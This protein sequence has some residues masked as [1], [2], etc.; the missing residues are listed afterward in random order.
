MSGAPIPAN[1]QARLAELLRY[2]ILD[3]AREAEFDGLTRLAAELC[4]SPIALISLVDAERQWFKSQV[5][6]DVQETPRKLA[7][8]AHSILGEGI[9]EV[10]DASKD[11]RFADNALVTGEPDIRFYAGAPLRSSEGF[12]LGTV[13]V[14]DRV[15]RRLSAAQRDGLAAIGRQVMSLLSFRRAMKEARASDSHG[16]VGASDLSVGVM[17]MATLPGPRGAPAR[18]E[19]GSEASMKVGR[20]TTLYMLGKGAMATVYAAHDRELQRKVA[21][22]FIHG[23]GGADEQQRFRHEAQALARISHPNVVQ[24][25]DSWAV[26]ARTFIAM[27]FVHGVTLAVWEKSRART[28][29]ETID[30]YIQAGR[31]LVAAHQVGVIHRDFKPD[32]VLVGIDGRPRVADF[33]LASVH[34]GA[35]DESS[36]DSAQIVGTPAYMAPEQHM[37]A[38]VDERADQF[39]FCA[40]LYESLHGVRPFAGGSLAEIRVHL[41]SGRLQAP[42]PGRR[43]PRAVY[44]AVARGLS[45]DPSQRWPSLAAL[46]DELARYDPRS[47]AAA[48]KRERV[49]FTRVFD[50]AVVVVAF[51]LFYTALGQQQYYTPRTLTLGMLVVWLIAGGMA[52]VFRTT[53]V[54]N[55]FHWQMVRLLLTVLGAVTVGRALAWFAGQQPAE[56]LLAGLISGG[57]TAAALAVFTAPFMA[58]IAAIQ[59]LAAVAIAGSLAPVLAIIGPGQLLSAFLFTR[60][61]R[62]GARVQVDP[63]RIRGGSSDAPSGRSL[64]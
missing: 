43:A 46:L 56:V 52:R 62:R 27:E 47:D 1:E 54:P 18:P 49:S 13:C 53:L 50:V 2:E 60:A 17:E 8:C 11:P 6:L 48:A 32:N 19:E 59:L 29:R 4:D 16:V 42:E 34:G 41:A 7:F 58:G 25:Y 45:L 3:S 64:P 12:A 36:E 15:P 51:G 5:G 31:G 10:E 20:F 44:D 63:V 9:L 21:I 33:G 24:I 38:T 61:W 26:A 22:K 57:T 28:L 35:D 39:S 23:S 55:V 40:A 37:A 30:M 14:I